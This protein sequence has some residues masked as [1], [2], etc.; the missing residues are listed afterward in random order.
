MMLLHLIERTLKVKVQIWTPMPMGKF[1]KTYYDYINLC[2]DQNR[3][4]A[5]RKLI[6]LYPKLCLGIINFIKQM[7]SLELVSK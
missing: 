2:H 7:K 6:W 5:I 1:I 3:F 4:S